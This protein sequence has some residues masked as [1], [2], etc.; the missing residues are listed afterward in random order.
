M[1]SVISFHVEADSV[2]EASGTRELLKLGCSLFE[3]E[4]DHEAPEKPFSMWP[5]MP[6]QPSSGA[7]SVLRCSWLPDRPL[8]FDPER[9]SKMWLGPLACQVTGFEWDGESFAGLARQGGVDQARVAFRSPVFFAANGR[10]SVAP[11]PRLMFTGYRRRWNALL[12]ETSPLRISDEVGREVN[13]AVEFVSYE[14]RTIKREG[15]HGDSIAG[16]IGEVALALRPGA[17]PQVRTVFGTLLRF[18]NYCGTGKGTTHGFGAT[19]VTVDGGS[20]D[21]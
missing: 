20:A 10:R 19:A 4:G 14:L 13:R 8:P 5:L 16:F 9:I 17:S 6:G 11:D 1:P 7:G 21:G 3:R 2:G 15:L 18:A 12:S